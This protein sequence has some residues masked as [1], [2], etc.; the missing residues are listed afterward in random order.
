MKK[1]RMIATNKTKDMSE[2][3]ART[4]V[5]LGRAEYVSEA[6]EEMESAVVVEAEPEME[7]VIQKPKRA[8]KRRDMKAED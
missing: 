4:M 3:G 2:R 7:D 6:E 5:L 1:V 8:Y